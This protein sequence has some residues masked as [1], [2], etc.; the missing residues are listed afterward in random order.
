MKRINIFA[1]N[2]QLKL[3][4]ILSGNFFLSTTN[5]YQAMRSIKEYD[6]VIY[7]KKPY[8]KIIKIC[9]LVRYCVSLWQINFII[10]ENYQCYS[11]T[12]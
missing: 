1:I 8:N 11:G 5:S 3:P 6:T 4:D 7:K 2:I 12:D 9:T 10:Y